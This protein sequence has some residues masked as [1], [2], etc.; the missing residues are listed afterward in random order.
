MKTK[1]NQPK[2]ARIA[3]DDM[4]TRLATVLLDL[5]GADDLPL[6]AVYAAADAAVTQVRAACVEAASG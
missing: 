5:R 1:I 4:R 2:A 3:D 6:D